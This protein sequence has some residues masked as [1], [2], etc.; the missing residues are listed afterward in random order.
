MWTWIVGGVAAWVVVAVVFGVVLGRGIRLADE[1]SPG[2]GVPRPLTPGASAARPV[3]RR[4]PLP[5]VGI[6]LAFLAVAL[7]TVGYA[8]RLDGSTGPLAQTLSMDA[9]WSLPRVY[10][11]ALFAAAA[12]AA[13]A[14]AARNPGRRTWWLAVGAV[15]AGIAVVKAGSTVHM[16]VMAELTSL[17]SPAG[18]VAISALGAVAVLAVLAFLSRAER[19]DRRRVLSTLGLYAVAAVGLSAVPGLVGGQWTAMATFVEESGEAL[20]GV[21]VLV[22]VLVGVAPRLVLSAAWLRRQDDALSLEAPAVRTPTVQE[23][24]R[25]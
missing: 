21:A 9:P 22:A 11:A 15:A 3:R 13:V 25:P 24:G 2:T 7:E 18:A 23:G 8:L 20:A 16:T 14:G 19:R 12:L 6:A 5:P 17:T 10:V 1:R 4:V